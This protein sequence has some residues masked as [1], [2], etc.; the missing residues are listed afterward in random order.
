MVLLSVGSEVPEGNFILHSQ[1]D[2]VINFSDGK[3]IVSLV[4]PHIGAGPH[5][6]ELKE[7]PHFHCPKIQVGKDFIACPPLFHWKRSKGDEDNNSF[8]DLTSITKQLPN[9][10]KD[11][12]RQYPEKGLVFLFAENSPSR[13]ASA[14]ERILK[15]KLRNAFSKFKKY[16]TMLE[17]IS[18]MKGLGHGLTPSGDDFNSGFLLSLKLLA[19]PPTVLK[20]AYESAIGTNLI[21]NSFLTQAYKGKLSKRFQALISELAKGKISQNIEQI[22]HS[23]G[24]DW[25]V[26]FL[27]GLSQCKEYKWTL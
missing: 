14:F 24:I 17:G 1:F 7:E 12:I 18:K 21:A 2:S 26:G 15:E 16:E 22:G 11:L 27:S 13:D 23:S 6:I 20:H 3:N 19:C 10:R 5:Y 9:L 8:F 25:L 4:G